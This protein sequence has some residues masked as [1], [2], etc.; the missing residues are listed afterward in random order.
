MDAKSDTLVFGSSV[1]PNS[2]FGSSWPHNLS[3]TAIR[4]NGNNYAQWARSVEVYFIA[5]KQSKFLNNYLPDCKEVGKAKYEDQLAED[6]QIHVL[7]W[8]SM[9]PNISVS[10][11]FL[12]TAKCVLNG[13][14]EGQIISAIPMRHTRH[15]FLLPSMI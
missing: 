1:V 7:L 13:A 14:K 11:I 10:L 15:S 5:K 4:L 6:A 12:N 3:I 8:N 9:E 2:T